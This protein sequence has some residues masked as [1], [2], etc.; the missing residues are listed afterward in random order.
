MFTVLT[1]VAYALV[2]LVAQLP[3]WMH[4]P[5]WCLAVASAAHHFLEHRRIIGRYVREGWF[6]FTLALD[7]FFAVMTPVFLFF[8][9]GLETPPLITYT[10]AAAAAVL[11]TDREYGAI[12]GAAY[13]VMIFLSTLA[14]KI[15]QKDLWG[16]LSVGAVFLFTILVGLFLIYAEEVKKDR[17]FHQYET[18][19]GIW[20]LMGAALLV[21]FAFAA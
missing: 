8:A 6:Q 18:L 11:G 12:V 4:L 14:F 3:I 21:A 10:F 5:F 7:K 13:I 17:K 15:L 2:P 19:H 1:N 16:A 20:H 9:V